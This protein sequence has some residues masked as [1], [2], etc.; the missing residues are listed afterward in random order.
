MTATARVY[1]DSGK[2]VNL[3]SAAN[4][5]AK[6]IMP[7]PI[8]QNVTIEEWGNIWCKVK[9]EKQ[10]GYMMTKFLR[11]NNFSAED[12]YSLKEQLEYALNLIDKLL[13]GE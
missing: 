13:K 5:Q 6:V 11:T 9:Y 2:T 10:T 7:V 3:R 4:T 1:A 8:G 12:L